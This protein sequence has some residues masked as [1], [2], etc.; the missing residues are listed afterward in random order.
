MVGVS[1]LIHEL[2]FLRLHRRPLNRVG[3]PEA[4]LEVGAGPEVL[5]LGLDHC[6]E[7]CQEEYDQRN[8]TTRHGSPSNT[9]TIPR[10][11]CV[12]GMAIVENL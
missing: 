9:N 8:S 10:R 12:A 3:R 5:E 4:V 6:P 2:E 7:D 11:I 1:T